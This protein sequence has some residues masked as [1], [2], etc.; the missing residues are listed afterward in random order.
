MKIVNIIGRDYVGRCVHTSK[1]CRGVVVRDRKV[2]MSCADIWSLPGGG[3]KEGETE[4]E[5]CRRE[6]AEETGVLVRPLNCF[7]ETHEFVKNIDWVN[8]FFKCEIIGKTKR[9][10]TEFEK[11]IGLEPQW[12]DVDKALS[13]L[14]KYRDFEGEN[15]SKS[16][17]YKRDYIVLKEFLKNDQRSKKQQ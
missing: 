9:D 13:V 16:L 7:I 8:R 12:I 6:V 1:R 2:L 3:M 5:C 14:S 4:A 17:I 11:Q 15:Y 10:L